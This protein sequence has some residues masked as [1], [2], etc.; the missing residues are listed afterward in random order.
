[1]IAIDQQDKKD[2]N[3]YGV[4]NFGLDENFGQILN[5]HVIGQVWIISSVK[6]QAHIENMIDRFLNYSIDCRLIQPESKFKFIEGL[7][8]ESGFD[9]YNVSF[10]PF[11]GT[12][13][14]LK[15]LIDKIFSIIFIIISLPIIIVF[16][17]MI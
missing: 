9:F 2:T 8:S 12:S 11:Y 1:M 13:F 6:T 4:P 5:H 14:L 16:S 15:T 17:I 7:D 3:F 10:S